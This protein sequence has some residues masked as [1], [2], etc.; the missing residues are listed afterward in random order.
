MSAP[1]VDGTF[2]TSSGILFGLGLG[3][4]FDGIVLHQLL[5]WHHMLSQWYPPNTVENLRIN[6]LW[7]GIFHSTTYV[8]VVVAI[9]L[10]LRTAHTRHLCWS[11]KLM[12]GTILIGFGAFNVVEGLIDHQLIGIHH[13]NELVPREQWP[14]CDF[15][16]I[17]WGVVLFGFGWV[18]N[19]MAKSEQAA[20]ASSFRTDAGRGPSGAESG[21]ACAW[22]ASSRRPGLLLYRLLRR[23]IVDPH[24][25]LPGGHHGQS[26]EGQNGQ[27]EQCRTAIPS[28]DQAISPNNH[29][30]HSAVVDERTDHKPGDA[31]R[32]LGHDSPLQ[33]RRHE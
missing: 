12:G 14:A 18:L 26:A 23:R 21:K 4:F 8:F 9:Y 24:D 13:V 3:G 1:R 27:D 32:K 11:P 20:A 22:F 5:Q 7:D 30:K 6:T 16:F 15:G 2:P 10:F 29:Q 17:A 31:P 25:E 33:E 28:G 19:R